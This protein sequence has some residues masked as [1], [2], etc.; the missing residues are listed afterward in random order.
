MW[1]PVDWN[2]ES[3]KIKLLESGIHKA[4]ILNPEIWILEPR[5]IKLLESEIESWNPE[6]KTSVDSVTRGDNIIS[7]LGP[8]VQN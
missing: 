4:G 2:P 7:G 3:R 1:N 6:S 5:K 8:V